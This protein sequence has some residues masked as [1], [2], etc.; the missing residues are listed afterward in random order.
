MQSKD[1]DV[2]QIGTLNSRAYIKLSQIGTLNYKKTP[3]TVDNSDIVVDNYLAE[4]TLL[5][6]QVFLDLSF[7]SV[8]QNTVFTMYLY[9]NKDTT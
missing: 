4:T 8:R 6:R 1:L 2:S 7:C 9:N 5:P 3:K